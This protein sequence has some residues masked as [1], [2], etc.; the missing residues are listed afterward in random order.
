MRL[1][2]TVWPSDSAATYFCRYF[3]GDTE[4]LPYYTQI[5]LIDGEIV[6]ACHIVKRT[7]ACGEMRL[8]MGG[9]A[10]VATLPEHRGQGYNRQC[11]EKAI[12]IME[13][14]ALDFSLLFTGVPDYY[15]KRGYARLPRPD[16]TG[17]IRPDFA[18]QPT[19]FMVRPT[20]ASDLPAV[21]ACYS[22][23]NSR[24]PIAIQRTEAYWRDWVGISAA[25]VPDTLFVATD[26]ALQIVGF[27]RVDSLPTGS[28]AE[29]EDEKTEEETEGAAEGGV[30]EFAVLPDLPDAARREAAFALWQEIAARFQAG[31]ISKIYGCI[32]FDSDVTD[33]FARV[34][35]AQEWDSEEDGM[36]RLLHRDNLFRGLAMDWGERWSAAGKPNGSVT[37]E[38]P[39]GPTRLQAN[40]SRMDIAPI[41]NAEAENVLSQSDFFRLLFGFGTLEDIAPNDALLA[42]LFPP[43]SP[44]YWSADGF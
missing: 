43:Q 26:S 2:E 33:A 16:W 3:Y 28:A 25:D 1:W 30:M 17:T 22:A 11:V 32:A 23:Y 5:A 31:G 21:R 39:Y 37:F 27:L 12:A 36:A 44:V 42:A 13:G 24:R 9:L 20:T 6:S 4:W 41:E 7:V 35:S 19:P 18:P 34:F 14:D 8:T 40:G 29:T 10:N 38:T 15:A